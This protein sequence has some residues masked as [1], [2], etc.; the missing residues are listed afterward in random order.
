M[1]G[2]HDKYNGA[3]SCWCA[4]HA[5]YVVMYFYQ[6]AWH[7]MNCTGVRAERQLAKYIWRCR[8]YRFA[9]VNPGNV[10]R[11]AGES[12]GSNWII[13]CIVAAQIYTR[14]IVQGR[15]FLVTVSCREN[16][17]TAMGEWAH[18]THSHILTLKHTCT[19]PHSCA[20]TLTHIHYFCWSTS[21]FL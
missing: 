1:I 15:L 5:W 18:H 19:P 13:S 10:N 2:L 9:L 12:V 21:A 16:W 8:G 6:S 17:R 14:I 3:V 4:L 11:A 7:M 20:L